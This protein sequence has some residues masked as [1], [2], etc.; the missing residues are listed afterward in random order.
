MPRDSKVWLGAAGIVLRNNEVLVVKKEY[1]G[2]KGKWSFP[3]G[4]VQPGERVDE[5]AEREVLEETGITA[6]ALQVVGV[7]SG[8][9][10]EEISDNMVVF[11]MEYVSGEPRPQVGEIETAQF[12]PVEE[13]LTSPLSTL[14][15]KA[16]LPGVLE[17]APALKGKDY[18]VDPIFNYTSYKI[19]S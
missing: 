16:I 18:H 9:I 13:V 17:M 8:V 19:F 4:F 2:M 14:Y 11:L 5:A 10:K 15:M 6:R 12:L 3:A 1:G 7:R